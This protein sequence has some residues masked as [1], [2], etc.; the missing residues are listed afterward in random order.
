MSLQMG[1]WLMPLD[2]LDIWFL[3]QV[4]ALLVEHGERGSI[5][6]ILNR[7]TGMVIG[8]KPSGMPMQLSVSRVALS[9]AN[10]QVTK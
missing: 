2:A 1:T 3:S 9:L 8:K 4:V 5:A 6:L 7:P 10:P